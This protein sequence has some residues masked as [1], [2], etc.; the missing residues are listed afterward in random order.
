MQSDSSE[1]FLKDAI[2]FYKMQWDDYGCFCAVCINCK[3]TYKYESKNITLAP[4]KWWIS[5]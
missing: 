2:G 5:F 4:K 3:C 1:L